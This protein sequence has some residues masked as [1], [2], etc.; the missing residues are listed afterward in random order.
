M[1]TQTLDKLLRDIGPCR[2]DGA[3][4]VRV[5]GVT[6]D[7][8]RVAPGSIFVAVSGTAVDGHSF[9]PA[10]IAAGAA[11]VVC[12]PAYTLPEGTAAGDATLVRPACGTAEALGRLASA[13]YGHPSRRL[14]LVGVTGTNGKTTIATL[15]YD[16]ARMRGERA[17]LLST[18]VN[19]IDDRAVPSTHTTPDPLELNA[20]LAEM[21]DAGCTFAAMEVSSHACAQRRIAGLHFAGGVFTNLTRDHLDYHKTFRAYLEAKKM[22]FDALPAGAWALVNADDSHAR[23]LVQNTRA[24][25]STYSL[26]GE[27]DFRAAVVEDRIDGMLLRIDGSEVHTAFAG[28][29]NASNLLAVYGAER[30]MGTPRTE[31]LTALSA[32]RP[33]AGRF[34]TFHGAGITAI[35]DYAHTPDALVN[36]LD[37]IREAAGT[38][39]DVITVCGCG[40]DRG[41][42]PMMAAE[43][44]RRSSLLVITSD[45]PRSEDPAAIAA[46]MLAGLDDDARLA[47]EVVLDRAEAIR[48]AIL[49][50]EPGGVV[51]V[52]GKGHEDYQIVGAERR[53]FDDREQV[54]AALA[55][56]A[57]QQDSK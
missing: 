32:L 51:L 50:A 38:G 13:W 33:V 53:H 14:T 2:I 16:M 1:Q 54:R 36:V 41:K 47:A 23:I 31:A 42:R 35:V 26:R 10:A 9:I 29:F 49:A 19:R 45:N 7:S 57:Q 44:A 55:L 46:D 5:S 17:G 52:A 27:A 8:R 22:F 12:D 3:A 25:V 15:L 11:A 21:V 39:A 28:R 30:L 43:A 56:R 6:A 40:G 20:L 18:V 24:R 34:Q 4:D 48:R 37:T